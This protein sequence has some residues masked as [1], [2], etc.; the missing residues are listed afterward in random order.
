MKRTAKAAFDP[1]VFLA[2]VGNC[3]VLNSR[4]EGKAGMRVEP[5]QS[6]PGERTPARSKA[7]PVKG[8][9]KPSIQ[10]K[11]VWLSA[12]SFG[13]TASARHDELTKHC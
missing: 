9:V 6:K 5:G 2:K 13:S 7:T 10:R 8:F 3:E 1:K 12:Y 11:E 4:F